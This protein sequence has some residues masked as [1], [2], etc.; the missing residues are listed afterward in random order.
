MLR[1]PEYAAAVLMQQ[2][3]YVTA[4]IEVGGDI[5]YITS[6]N[7][8]KAYPPYPQQEYEQRMAIISSEFNFTSLISTD[9]NFS[10]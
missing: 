2:P 7:G 5:H 10:S 8:Y 3:P 4:A 1:N 9:F 6:M